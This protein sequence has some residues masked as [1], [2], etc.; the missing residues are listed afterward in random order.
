M[1][2]NDIKIRQEMTKD[3]AKWFSYI[4]QKAEETGFGNLELNLTVKNGKVVNIKNAI[5]IENFN[6]RG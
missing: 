5:A 4:A 6:I 3:D 1:K 2:I